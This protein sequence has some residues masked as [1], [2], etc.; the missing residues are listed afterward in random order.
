MSANCPVCGY[1]IQVPGTPAAKASG[2]RLHGT[3]PFCNIYVRTREACPVCYTRLCYYD[4]GNRSS[5]PYYDDTIGSHATVVTDEDKFNSA[6]TGIEPK[7]SDMDVIMQPKR[8]LFESV[9]KLPDPK[10]RL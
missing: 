3:S 2:H 4:Y 6:M 10:R 1:H 8:K 5:I 7:L 9:I